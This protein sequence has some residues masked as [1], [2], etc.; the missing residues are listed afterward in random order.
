MRDKYRI[1]NVE[2]TLLPPKETVKQ[3][4][5]KIEDVCPT[6]SYLT[7]FELGTKALHWCGNDTSAK[8]RRVQSCVLIDEC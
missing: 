4:P 7:V 2:H 1:R 5:N 3:R 8:I 6:L